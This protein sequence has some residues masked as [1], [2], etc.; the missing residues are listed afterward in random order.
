[1]QWGKKFILHGHESFLRNSYTQVCKI[2]LDN[3][4]KFLKA[5]EKT[6]KWY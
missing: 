5:E 1:M 3:F 4:I 6:A 2:Q